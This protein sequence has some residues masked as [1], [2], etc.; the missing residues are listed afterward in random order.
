MAS[1]RLG[2]IGIAATVAGG[3]CALLFFEL[4]EREALSDRGFWLGLGF[5]VFAYGLLAGFACGAAAKQTSSGKASLVVSGIVVMVLLGKLLMTLLLSS[6][7][8]GYG[9]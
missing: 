8:G 7:N 4:L 2:L 5:V 6:I 9:R 1:Q 3:S